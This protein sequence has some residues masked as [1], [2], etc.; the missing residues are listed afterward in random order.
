VTPFV[1]QPERD[2][3]LFRNKTLEGILSS[4]DR[5]AS[6]LTKHVEKKAQEQLELLAEKSFIEELLDETANEVDRAH[7][8]LTKVKELV[9]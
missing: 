3:P 7:R 1:A 9:A 4:F 8:V 2:L 5:V 6:D